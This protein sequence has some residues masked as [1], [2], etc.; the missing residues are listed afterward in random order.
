[1]TLKRDIKNRTYRWHKRIRTKEDV[2]AI[3]RLA[4]KKINHKFIKYIV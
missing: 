2:L 3:D 1:M 4:P